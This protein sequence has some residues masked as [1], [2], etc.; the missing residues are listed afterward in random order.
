MRLIRLKLAA[1]GAAVALAACGGGSGAGDQHPQVAFTNMVSFGDSLS[2]IGTYKVG[3]IAALGG[4]KWTV[5]G[6]TAK[7]WTELIA[8][9]IMVAPPCAA[10]TG[11][12]PNIPGLVGAAPVTNI[13]N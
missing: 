6:P 12:L 2:D 8:A 4:G 13:P 9:D 11:L 10:E 5:N 7:N 1:L 3:T